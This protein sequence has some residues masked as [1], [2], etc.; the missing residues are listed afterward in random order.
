MSPSPAEIRLS[1]DLLAPSN[2][3]L[4]PDNFPPEETGLLVAKIGERTPFSG[5]AKNKQQTEK[6]KL[7]DVF[8]KGDLYF[9]SGDLLKIDSEG[10][11]FFQDRIGDTF[12]CVGETNW[13]N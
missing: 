11:V 5:Y 12:R 7:R 8:V 13:T 2:L 1:L 10:F 3:Y 4:V 6:K 9:N